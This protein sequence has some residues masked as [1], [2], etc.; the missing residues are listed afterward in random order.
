MNILSAQILDETALAHSCF[1]YYCKYR[2][3][4]KV[5][6]IMIPIPKQITG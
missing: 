2:A 5:L 1:A 4:P 6:G 3:V